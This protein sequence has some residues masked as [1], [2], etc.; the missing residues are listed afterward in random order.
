MIVPQF[1]AESRVQYRRRDRQVTIRRFGWSDASEEEAQANADARAHAALERVLSGENLARR[2]PKI[3]YNGAEGVPIR[4]EIVARFGE[5]VVTR[6]S[7]G[8]RCLNTPNVFF[9][10]IDFSDRPP[11]ELS[12]L[13][14]VAAFAA[15][16][17][18]G[19]NQNSIAFGIIIAG[20][21]FP[22]LGL[23]ASFLYKGIHRARGGAEGV[24][25][26]RIALF[27]EDHPDW[28]LRLYRTPAGL[29]ILAAH[30]TFLPGS[31]EV[32]EC[33]AALG[34]DPVYVQMC[35]NQQCF[36]ARVSAKPWRIGIEHHMKPVGAW[37]VPADRLPLRTAWVEAYESSASG[38]AACTFVETLGSGTIH[39]QVRGVQELHD[40]LSGALSTLPI[41]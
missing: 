4:E 1:W 37:P 5:T 34:T 9:A 28:S 20:V 41:A 26:S 16:C 7:Y 23:F 18:M 15:A 27:L 6:N 13:V 21:A 24:A 30:Q 38:Y 36:R 19:L 40:K 29:R 10:D 39:P 17:I 3:P 8:A 31:D 25:R 22:L 32:E 11:P 2:E 12:C 14:L 35:R 33:F